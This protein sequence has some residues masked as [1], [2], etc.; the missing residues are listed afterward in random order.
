MTAT[1]TNETIHTATVS[2]E[3]LSSSNLTFAQTNPAT[4]SEMTGTFA[5]PYSINNE[6]LHTATM[7]NEPLS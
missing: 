7:T 4:F 2:N 6:T 5:N 3:V 1:L